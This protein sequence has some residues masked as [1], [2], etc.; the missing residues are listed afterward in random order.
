MTD[1]AKIIKRSEELFTATERNQSE[2]TWSELLEFMLNNQSGTFSSSQSTGAGGPSVSS[3]GAKKTRR[4]FDSTAMQAVQELASS[5]QG[6]LTNPATVWSQL[7]FSDE[8]LNNDDSAIAWLSAVNK[9][10][11]AKLNE[12]NFNTEI[13]KSYQSFVALA[14][15]A[16]LHEEDN[17]GG[18]RFT[19]VHLGQIAWAEDRFGVVDTVHR[20][21]T[22]TASQA[23]SRWGG[24]LGDNIL[25]A[26][27]KDPNKEFEFLHS[28]F[29]RAK[30]EVKL[31]EFGLAAAQHRPIASTYISLTDK[32]LVEDGG[33]YEMPVYVARWGL[34]PGERYGRGPAHLALPDTR[35]LNKTIELT[36][37]AA[38]KQIDPPLLVN[39]RDMFG[40]LDMRPGS[41]SVVRD[42]RGISSL[43][44]NA[45]MQAVEL[46]ISRLTDSIRKIF[47]LDKLLLPPRNE[48]GEMTA[49]EVSQR[50]EQM[51][52]VL[53]P[54]LSR[55][56]N[57]LLSPLIVRC[58]KVLL[59]NNVLPELPQILQER[60]VDVDIVFVNQLARAQQAQD[61]STMQQWVQGVAMIAQLDP[62]VIDNINADG[63]ARHM[64]KVMG[65]PEEA[66]QNSDIVK[67]V[68]DQRAQAQAQAAQMQSGTQMA[69]MASKLGSMK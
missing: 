29:P 1:P 46:N 10:V 19:A 32:T 63:I 31:N 17:F 21:F 36:L 12:S 54:V 50:I 45:N 59:R 60:G 14:N 51:Q 35:T 61:V 67:Q 43:P 6:T 48:T 11:H 22:L 53:G 65:V 20:K 7:R 23:F 39:Q 9:A 24:E 41:L 56:N 33:Y 25:R 37:R 3:Q 28:I 34:M 18:F 69:D 47:F 55:V 40:Q 66:V 27:D 44:T 38:A 5:F 16:L 58:F 4:L 26:L 30:S 64:A 57:E 2:G 52:R 13:A 8:V 62:S 15:M 42:H 49:F 68:R